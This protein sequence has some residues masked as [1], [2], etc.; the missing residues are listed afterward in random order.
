[1]IVGKK[2]VAP[3]GWPGA[4]AKRHRIKTNILAPPT[5]LELGSGAVD[6]PRVIIEPPKIEGP[7]GT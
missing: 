4:C 7:I 1:M 3:N 5:L 6:E 2:S